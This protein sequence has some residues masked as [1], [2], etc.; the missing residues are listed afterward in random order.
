L[1][2]TQ[3]LE[4][5]SPVPNGLTPQVVIIDCYCNQETCFTG[6]S[7]GGGSCPLYSSKSSSKSNYGNLLRS[8]SEWPRHS[9][10]ICIKTKDMEEM[11]KSEKWE[12]IRMDLGNWKMKM[13]GKEEEE[14]EMEGREP[15]PAW[16][17]TREILPPPLLYSFCRTCITQCSPNWLWEEKINEFEHVC[18]VCRRCLGFTLLLKFPLTVLFLGDFQISNNHYFH[19][20]VFEGKIK[21]DV[22][23]F[24]QNQG[25]LLDVCYQHCQCI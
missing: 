25:V 14:Q 13:K 20:P 15:F 23:H 3:T 8:P 16:P 5:R 17:F 9:S 10:S 12:E 22:E 19:S 2:P 1:S 11:T 21:R 7:R 18:F 6:G 24:V 4:T